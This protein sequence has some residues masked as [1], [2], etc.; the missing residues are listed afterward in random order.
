MKRREN[1]TLGL[2]AAGQKELKKITVSYPDKRSALLPILYL[3]QDEKGFIN[4]EDQRAV[5]QMLQMPPMKV[6]GVVE[7]YTMLRG[8]KCGKYLIQ[9]CNTLSCSIMGSHA[10]IDIIRKKLGTDIGE[11]TSDGKFTL[12]K[13]ECLGSCGTAPVMQINDDYYENLTEQKISEILDSLE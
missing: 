8:E 1:I 4:L 11:T 10:V 5:A 3:I 12:V 9:V 13:V 7:F 2:S 6:R